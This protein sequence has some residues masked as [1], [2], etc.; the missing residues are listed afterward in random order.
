MTI[1]LFDAPKSFVRQ[2]KSFDP[3]LRIRWS[4]WEERWRLERRITHARSID[5]G[6]FLATDY[7][8]FVARRDGYLPILFCRKEQLDERIFE[9]LWMADMHRHGGAKRMHDEAERME[10]ERRTKSRAKYLDDVYYKAKERWNYANSLS[11]QKR[12]LESWE[13]RTV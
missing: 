2:L 9:T 4:D 11:S 10:V 3:L 6:L 1:P 12:Q 5:P 13:H 7:E 8:E